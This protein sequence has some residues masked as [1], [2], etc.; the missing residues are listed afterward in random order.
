MSDWIEISEQQPGMDYFVLLGRA[1]WE[2][3]L[4]GWRC[5]QDHYRLYGE[6][7]PMGEKPTHWMPL[8]KLPVPPPLPL[9][10]TEIAVVEPE[11]NRHVLLWS[12][13]FDFVSR[14]VVGY[15]VGVPRSIYRHVGG[16]QLTQ[17]PT[18]WMLFPESGP[19]HGPRGADG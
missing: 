16:V 17:Q 13:D 12:E 11:V 10:W 18:H 4:V 1:G 19:K 9:T 15:R 8:P 2:S 3:P 14:P 7:K 6:A 5:W